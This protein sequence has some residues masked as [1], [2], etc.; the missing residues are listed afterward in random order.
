IVVSGHR[1]FE[2]E[3]KSRTMPR[4]SHRRRQ[5]TDFVC[6]SLLLVAKG[7]HLEFEWN[8]ARFR[9]AVAEVQHPDWIRAIRS[10][11]N[12]VRG[13]LLNGTSVVDAAE[14]CVPEVCVVRLRP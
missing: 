2:V 10:L 6:D 14:V 9:A 13:A 3:V 5:A 11:A 1:P 4:R 8:G 12:E 7:Y